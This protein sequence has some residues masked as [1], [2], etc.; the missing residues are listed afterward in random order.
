VPPRP[1]PTPSVVLRPATGLRIVRAGPVQAI[2]R[3][4]DASENESGYQVFRSEAA[5]EFV[6][7]A[8][9]AANAGEYHDRGLRPNVRYRYRVRAFDGQGR[10]ADSA[11]L[12][13]P[14]ARQN[15]VASR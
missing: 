7:V 4:N 11:V 9:L 8:T 1:T 15:G 2:I 13:V 6:V 5:K 10:F 3:W 12:T 14:A